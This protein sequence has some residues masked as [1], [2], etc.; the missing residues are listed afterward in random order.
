V[1]NEKEA[2]WAPKQSGGFGK[3]K[4]PCPSQELKIKYFSCNV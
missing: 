3:K 1:T 2:G 4:N